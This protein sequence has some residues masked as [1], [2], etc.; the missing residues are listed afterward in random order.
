MVERVDPATG[1]TETEVEWDMTEYNRSAV[2]R[3]EKEEFCRAPLTPVPT[4]FVS[5]LTPEAF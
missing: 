1:A 3:Y 4:P 5:K 2:S